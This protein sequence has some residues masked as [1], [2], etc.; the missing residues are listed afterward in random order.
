MGLDRAVRF[1]SGTLPTWDSI[2]DRLLA[3]GTPVTLRM[4]DGMPAFPDESPEP[5]W[6]EIRLGTVAG[7]VTLRS[8]ASGLTCIVWGSADPALLREW[9]AVCWACASAGAGLVETPAGPIGADDF[10][11]ATNLR[12]E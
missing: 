3:V 4:I 10:A 6:R 11:R 2:R 5:G 12:P 8:I 9:D 1:P 7:M